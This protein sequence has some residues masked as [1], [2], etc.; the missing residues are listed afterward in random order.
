M[1]YREHGMWEVLEVLR[2][3][4][5]GVSYRLIA[6]RTGHS[7]NTVRRYVRGAEALGWDRSGTPPSEELAARVLCGCQPGGSAEGQAGPTQELLDGW[8]SDLK[9]W[10]GPREG[11][12]GGLTLTK[13]HELLQRRG[14]VVPYSSLHRYVVKHCGFG[15]PKVSVRMAEVAPGELAEVDFGRLGLVPFA[16]VTGRRRVLHAL[17]VT[18]VHSRH[19]YVHLTHSQDLSALIEGLEAA[20]EFFG[21]VPRRV[22]LDNLKAA[23]TKA[24]RYDPAINRTFAEYAAHRG[25]VTDAARVR[26]P[27][28]KPHVER[29]VPY[30]R[31]S[32]FRGERFLHRDHAQRCVVRW[33]LEK[34]GKRV[35][36]TTRKRPLEQFEAHEREALSPL[37]AERFDTPSWARPKVHPDHHIRFG[38][39]LYSVPTALIG[40]CV[41]V[42][43]DSS[44][45][46]IYHAGRLVKTHP[47]VPKGQRSTDFAD[48]PKE[49]SGYAM[50]CPESMITRA[51][52]QGER[53][54]TLMSRLLE[55]EF[56]WAR[57]RQAQKLLRLGEKYGAAR[58]EAACARA[59]A[60]DLINVHRVE[61][62]IRQGVQKEP[63]PDRPAQLQQMPLRFERDKKS[64]K[65]ENHKEPYDGDQ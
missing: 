2:Q 56:P 53:T 36:G 13:C 35:H 11:D 62:I 17:V 54:G 57:L 40:Q 39:A 8:R 19:Q 55:G 52:Q 7:R 9:R 47:K 3:A 4:H 65:P 61:R 14:V 28:G 30:V 32:F 59:L 45:V 48:Y 37:S 44:L 33:C 23:I 5:A 51:R 18:L 50:R 58:L 43:G 46:R 1:A 26:D 64:F 15:G 10:L 25:F 38:N 60:F 41:D 31:E 22:V 63:P 24:D 12:E 16:P 34:A 42:R 27:Q 20:W 6:A 29:Q 49:K 21:G